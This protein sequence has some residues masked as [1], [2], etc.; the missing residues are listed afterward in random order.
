[1]ALTTAVMKRD[2]VLTCVI[3]AACHTLETAGVIYLYTGG[4]G[5]RRSKWSRLDARLEYVT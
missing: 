1:M 2:S 3:A 5:V 4:S